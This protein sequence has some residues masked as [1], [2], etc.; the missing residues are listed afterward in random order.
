MFFKIVG[1]SKIVLIDPKT[2][3]I[4]ETFD[5]T[6][7]ICERFDLKKNC[8]SNC[9]NGK[10][11]VIKN[12]I[13]RY[14]KVVTDEKINKWCDNL[15]VSTDGTFKCNDCLVWKDPDQFKNLAK[16]GYRCVDCEKTRLANYRKTPVGFFKAMIGTMQM[17]TTQKQKKGRNIC[18]VEIT[19]EDLLELYLQQDEKCYYTG[20]RLNLGNLVD[21]R[22]SPE[23]LNENKGYT[24]DNIKLICLEF[25]N[26]NG[27]WTH[28]KIQ[29]LSN[30]VKSDVNVE[31]LENEIENARERKKTIQPK[32]IERK[33]IE[34]M[35]TKYLCLMCNIHKTE[36]CFTTKRGKIYSKCK[37]CDTKRKREDKN[38]L[39]GYIVCKLDYAKKRSIK[40]RQ[41][42]AIDLN[43]AL[44]Q[45]LKQNGRCYYSGIPLVFKRNTEW[46]CSFE[47]LNGKIGYTK[48]NTILICVEF[49]SIDRSI[50]ATYK[51]SGSGQ[52]S[53]EK[54]NFL[55]A[56][57][58][59]NSK[60]SEISVDENMQKKN[61]IKTTIK[62]SDESPTEKKPTKK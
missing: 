20:I 60:I 25:N 30:M 31:K 44:D 52:W 27:K 28:K 35:T 57:L 43:W 46:Q 11:N 49:N 19:F 5:T 58:E 50:E 33:L 41:E 17:S 26:S 48:E 55:L 6:D 40:R 13:L 45:I 24:K 34:E 12:L 8:I 39:R 42:F 61:P 9:L 22:C 15:N 14:H 21:W 3:S 59:K 1:M 36:D 2:R 51:N 10:F 47:R 56:Q 32:R 62:L 38:K 23:R 4:V 53:K 37:T 54:F 7:E 16:A 18:T 29:S